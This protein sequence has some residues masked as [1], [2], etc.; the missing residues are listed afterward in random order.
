M[1]LVFQNYAYYLFTTKVE[2]E[3]TY[4][5]IAS[6]IINHSGNSTKGQDTDLKSLFC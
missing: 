1:F 3:K 6:C 4:T 5:T 2:H